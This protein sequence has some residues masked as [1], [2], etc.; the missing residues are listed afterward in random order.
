MA[1]KQSSRAP[2]AATNF[3]SSQALGPP[4][5]TPHSRKKKRRLNISPSKDPLS[6]S[7][8][9][10]PL[11]PLQQPHLH[12]LPSL[13]LQEPQKPTSSASKAIIVVEKLKI[14]AQ[15]VAEANQ[16]CKIDLSELFDSL[17]SR[18]AD[19]ESSLA[20]A[21][22]PVPAPTSALSLT[23]TLAA[24]PTTAPTT[25]PALASASASAPLS[26]TT[27]VD[28]PTTRPL[29]ST[30]LKKA[31]EPSSSKLVLQLEEVEDVTRRRDPYYLR[32]RVNE[33]LE[34]EAIAGISIIEPKKQVV[35]YTT[36]AFTTTYIYQNMPLLLRAL[37]SI[38]VRASPR[39]TVPT[40]DI[41]VHGFPAGKKLKFSEIPEEYDLPKK[42]DTAEEIRRFTGLVAR[43]SRWLVEPKKDQKA[44]SKVFYIPQDYSLEV[45]RC[46][47][48]GFFFFGRRL[49]VVRYDPSRGKREKPTKATY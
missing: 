33:L 37:S 41:V 25:A 26:A 14:A 17:K 32:Q 12:P 45:E 34:V 4:T 31:R 27:A 3:S 23:A 22:A 39:S 48:D 10:Q 40:I 36:P 11:Q 42:V 20:P 19:L 18:V 30:I 38:G 5:P 8:Q 47:R 21:P 9:S 24:T 46:L 43:G 28:T 15:L 1:G 13:L 44:G 35:L 7:P 16:I 29:Y 2:A 49:R 6:E